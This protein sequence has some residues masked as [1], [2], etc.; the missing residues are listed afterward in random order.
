MY[1]NDE[2]I[3]IYG[4]SSVEVAKNYGIDNKVYIAEIDVEK[5]LK[6]KNTNWKYEALPKYPAMVR[7]IAVIVNNEVLA[8]EMIETIE[9]VNTELI[10]SV[11]CLTYTRANMF[12]T[13]I[14]QLHFL[15]LIET[16]N[17]L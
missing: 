16:K 2:L 13:D 12:K 14:N 6:Y 8:G 10:E 4:E 3:G 1:V 9:S 11:N 7:D 15:L 17:V 5:L